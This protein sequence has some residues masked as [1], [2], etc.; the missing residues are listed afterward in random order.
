MLLNA[1]KIVRFKGSSGEAEAM[2]FAAELQGR[3]KR[4]GATVLITEATRL[5]PF[6]AMAPPVSMA[7]FER[8]DLNARNGRQDAA[9]R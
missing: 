2:T 8:S 4:D 6:F 1:G 5:V 7:G 3:C 9:R